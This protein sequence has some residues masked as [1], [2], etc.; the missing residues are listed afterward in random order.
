MAHPEIGHRILMRLIKDL[1]EVAVAETMP[2]QEGNQM[3]HDPD[4]QEGRAE[5]EERRVTRQSRLVKE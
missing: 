5:A 3:P 2:R 1:E 4:G